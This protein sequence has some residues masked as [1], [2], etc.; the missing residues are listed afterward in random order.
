MELISVN[1]NI[2][3][4][5]CLQ[6]DYSNNGRNISQEQA[7][8]KVIAGKDIS[9]TTRVLANNSVRSL[10]F[11]TI[12]TTVRGLPTQMNYD[13]YLN[14]KGFFCKVQGNRVF[15]KDLLNKQVKE[16]ME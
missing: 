16:D 14:S 11:A 10:A 6:R 9:D 7:N 2:W 13:I 3:E 8:L 12:Q 4:L 15:L 1:G 5:S